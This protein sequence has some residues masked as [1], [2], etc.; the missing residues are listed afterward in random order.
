MVRIVHNL[1]KLHTALDLCYSTKADADTIG[2][3]IS[4]DHLDVHRHP[5]AIV[6]Q[7][8]NDH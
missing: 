8:D 5:Q 3:D 4:K 7:F 2:I 6:K 1:L